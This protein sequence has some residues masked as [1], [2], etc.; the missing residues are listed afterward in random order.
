MNMPARM[1]I[2][3]PVAFLPGAHGEDA[4]AQYWLRQVTLRMRREVCWLWRERPLQSG[5][6][7]RASALPPFADPALGALDLA[8]YRP[9]QAGVFRKRRNGRASQ[10]TH[11]R[12]SAS[13]GRDAWLVRLGRAGTRPRAGRM[14]RA[15]GRADAVGRQRRGQRHR[16]LSER[17][18]AHRSDVCARAAPVGF[19]RRARA[20][21][22]PGASAAEPRPAR[23]SRVAGWNAVLTVPALVAR[24]LLFPGCRTARVARTRGSAGGRRGPPDSGCAFRVASRRPHAHRPGDRSAGRAARRGRGSVRCGERRQ[25]GAAEQGAR[26]RS[27]RAC[28]DDSVASRQHRLSAGGPAGQCGRS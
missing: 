20:V 24:E 13:G 28:A 14:L 27:T 17:S 16:H 3:D 4:L 18:G 26:P 6:E 12:V 21:L 2:S 7:T 10:R 8:R 5:A 19:A 9:R 1:P 22:R 25:N 15:G 11:C 23:R